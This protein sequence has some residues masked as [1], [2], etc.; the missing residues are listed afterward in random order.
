MLQSIWKSKKDD[1]YMIIKRGN[2]TDDWGRSSENWEKLYEFYTFKNDM[3]YDTKQFFVSKPTTRKSSTGIARRFVQ[4]IND[5]TFESQ[6]NFWALTKWQPGLKVIFLMN[7]RCNTFYEGYKILLN[8]C[9]L[10]IVRS[11]D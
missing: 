4:T 10:L 6:Y 5:T 1:S 8:E 2:N 3:G 9:I 7:Q 11:F